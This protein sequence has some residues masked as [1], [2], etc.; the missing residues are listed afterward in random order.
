MSLPKFELCVMMTQ[1]GKTFVAVDLIKKRLDQ[2]SATIHIVFTMNTLLNNIQFSKRL[3]S[4]ERDYGKGSIC[5]LSS[6]YSGPYQ[7][8][9]S[10]SSATALIQK[11]TPKVIIMCSHY[12]RFVDGF[13]LIQDHHH[14]MYLYFDELHHYISPKIRNSIQDAHSLPHIKGIL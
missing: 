8:V 2:D 5:I 9:K 10:F 6:K 3:E 1:S 7:H 4:I 11:K 12:K 14:D 13:L